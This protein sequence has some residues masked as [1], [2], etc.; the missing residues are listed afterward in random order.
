MYNI[1]TESDDSNLRSAQRTAS[2]KDDGEMRCSRVS[3]LRI[4]QVPRSNPEIRVKWSDNLHALSHIFE[5]DTRIKHAITAYLHALCVWRLHPNIRLRSRDQNY[6]PWEFVALTT[7]HPLSGKVVTNFPDKRRS[8]GRYSS[9][10]NYGYGVSFLVSDRRVWTSRRI[11]IIMVKWNILD[12][13][14]R[15]R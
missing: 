7:Q 13:K 12:R 9:L 10:A 15:L 4:L 2:R 3:L 11:M 5:E 6:R 1:S 8:L 14:Y